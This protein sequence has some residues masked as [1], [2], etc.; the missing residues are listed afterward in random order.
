MGSHARPDWTEAEIQH[1]K[2]LCD[3]GLYR[4]CDMVP[5][6][7]RTTSGIHYKCY[8]LGFRNAYRQPCTYEHDRAFF[9]RVT[10]ETCYWA[11][12]MTTDGTILRHAYARAGLSL[13]VA[14]KDMDLVECWKATI[15][16]THPIN[17]GKAKCQLSTKDPNAYHEH[18]TLR[19]DSAPELVADLDRVF[20]ITYSKTLRCPP[21]ELPDTLHKLC[22]MRGYVDGDGNI[23][24]SNQLG[25]MSVGVCGCNR[26][27][28]AN[29]KAIVDDL[30][31]PHIHPARRPSLLYQ[32]EGENCYYYNLRG[33]RAAV[34][35]ELLRRTP[36]P[37]MARKWDNP[38]V[39]HH[40][41]HWK[42]Q[43]DRWPPETWFAERLT[44]CPIEACVAAAA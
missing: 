18:C 33:F 4:F 17:R 39:L 25:F 43:A 22:Y 12:I 7:G 1:L 30:D 13:Q 8:A 24:Q 14:L 34:L 27:L 15:K 6:L 28:I 11:G 21:P 44:S 38:R 31:I 9:S 3:T 41:Q 10:P 36:T 20:N 23:T 2:Q 16:A 42:D 29:I 26:E 32:G 19:L 40:V 5:L 35:F 37:N